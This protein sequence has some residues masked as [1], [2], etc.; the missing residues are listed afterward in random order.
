MPHPL[1]ADTLTLGELRR[2]PLRQIMS[3]PVVTAEE[4][5]TAADAYR[6]MVQHGI[7]HLPVVSPV[8]GRL[9]G[10]FSRTDAYRLA[11]L[12]PGEPVEARLDVLARLRLEAVMSTPAHALGPEDTVADAARLM[13]DLR[14]GAVPIVDPQFRP[15]GIVTEVD[16]LRLLA[17]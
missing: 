8:S 11:P 2:L 16:L 17:R 4:D 6:R 10:M 14:I 12:K 1:A 7:R 5:E 9:L 15:I 3:A 13:A